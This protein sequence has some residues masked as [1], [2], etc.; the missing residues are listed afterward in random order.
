MDDLEE[1]LFRLQVE[2]IQS[3]IKKIKSI[4]NYSIED[5]KYIQ[6]EK[7]GLITSINLFCSHSMK[8][9]SI[10][11]KYIDEIIKFQEFVSISE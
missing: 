3:W 10:K 7:N 4:S 11:H 8:L 2:Y 1:K 5:E 9:T 6:K